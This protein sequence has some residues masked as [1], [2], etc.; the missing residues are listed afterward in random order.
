MPIRKFRSIE[1]MDG[2]VW[3]E[4]GDSELYRAIR[5]TWD[6]ARRMN[7]RRFP[8]GVHKFR[9]IDEMNRADDAR[10]AEHV[11]SRRQ[12]VLEGEQPHSEADP[13]R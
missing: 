3:R 11:R 7:P 2:N 12:A 1:E 4:P 10:L 9:S 6:L 13:K 8:P 5:F